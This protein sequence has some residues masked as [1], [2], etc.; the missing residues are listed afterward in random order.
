MARALRYA[1]G[2][3]PA[4]PELEQLALADRFG[5]AAVFDGQPG[6]G[7]MRRMLVVERIVAAWRGREASESWANWAATHR[8]ENALLTRATQAYS[9]YYDET[10]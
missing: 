1:Q 7:E 2:D 3:G 6:V 4:P 8:A 9:E 10:S 5:A